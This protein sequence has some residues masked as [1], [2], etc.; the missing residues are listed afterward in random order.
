MCLLVHCF[1]CCCTLLRVCAEDSMRENFNLL[2]SG[3]VSSQVFIRALNEDQSKI[4]NS[5]DIHTL[6][7][8]NGGSDLSR[9]LLVAR[10]CS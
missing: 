9:H 4:W 1:A 10:L 7:V 2:M 6:Y 8:D 5:V 3:T